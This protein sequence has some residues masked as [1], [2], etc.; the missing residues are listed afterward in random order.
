MA[1]T[2]M[3]EQQNRAVEV[4]C[5]VVHYRLVLAVSSA[6]ADTNCCLHSLELVS[7]KTISQ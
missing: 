7:R 1:A 2:L 5:I 3:T 6:I 4:D